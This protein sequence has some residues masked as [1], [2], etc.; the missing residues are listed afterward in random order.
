M[1]KFLT[2]LLSLVMVFSLCLTAVG[3]GG[4]D[5]G[6]DATGDEKVVLH[7]GSTVSTTHAWYEA[8]ETFQKNLSEASG[9]TMEVQLDFGGVWGSDKENAEAVQNGTLD[10]YIGSTV[11]FDAIVT[12]IGY[13]N[14]PYLVTTYDQ[15]DNLIYNGWIGE[16]II[17]NAEE[18]GFKILGLTDC[19]FRWL[20]N[21]KGDI[22][23]AAD[24]KGLKMRVPESPMFLSFFENLGAVPT[25]MA[26]TEVASALQQK[27]VDGQDNGP[28]LTYTYGFHQFNT[29]VTKSNHS[30]ASAVVAFNPA[31]WDSLSA[32]QQEILQTAATQYAE[33]V[34]V[35]AREDVD[36]MSQL[37]VD[38]GCNVIEPTD[39]LASD[40]EDAAQ[41]VWADD[42]ATGNFDQDA[43]KRIRENGGAE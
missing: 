16:N 9:G 33:D 7:L 29:Y 41:K 14:L 31:K 35:L 43:M 4:D 18:Q 23:S 34:K 26:I 22:K 3:C 5:N 1:K 13:V 11:G 42:D 10:M 6:G 27:T 30:F 2:A 25:S 12:D 17:A 32:E 36:E 40:M 20:T 28:V 8:A 21:S 19:D 38:E 15:V 37:M 24:I 39:Q